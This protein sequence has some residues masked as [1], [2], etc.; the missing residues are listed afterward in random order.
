MERFHF[1]SQ[2]AACI[3]LFIVAII[4]LVFSSIPAIE[5]YYREFISMEMGIHI[6]HFALIKQLK[7]WVNDFL[8]TLFFFFLGLEIKREVLVGEL[9]DKKFMF[10]IF[11]AGMGGML[12]SGI[13][14]WLCNFHGAYQA[15]WGVPLSTDTA[16]TL[17]ILSFFRK[18]LPSGVFT[19]MAGLAVIDDIVCVSIIALF[20]SHPMHSVF[21]LIVLGLMGFSAFLNYCGVRHPAAYLG[22]ALIAWY[23]TELTGVHGALVGVLIALTVPARPKRGSKYVKEHLRELLGNFERSEI[24]ESFIL[25]NEFMHTILQE[26]QRTAKYATTPLQSW[27]GFLEIPVAF[28]ILPAFVFCNAGIRI[29]TGLFFDVF[30][31]IMPL[32]IIFSLIVGKFIGVTLF[33]RMALWSTWGK[34]PENTN[35]QHIISLSL[36]SGIGFTMALFISNFSFADGSYELSLVKASIMISSILSALIGIGFLVAFPRRMRSV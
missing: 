31:H 34:L 27:K 11:C 32:S 28:F 18:K 2:T 26:V 10:L 22:M 33:S 4:A 23:F 29:N 35:F 25:E 1:K 16:F 8:L 21:F 30:K 3:L 20:Y 6:S 24:K 7:N 19:F 17:G 12:M 14:Y 36:L 5:H 15:A 9:A 13:T